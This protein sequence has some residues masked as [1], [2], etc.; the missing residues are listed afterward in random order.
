MV[1]RPNF[2]TTRS[3]CYALAARELINTGETIVLKNYTKGMHNTH[4]FIVIKQKG[5]VHKTFLANK[6]YTCIH[7]VESMKIICVSI[8]FSLYFSMIILIV[9]MIWPLWGKIALQFNYLC[10]TYFFFYYWHYTNSFIVISW[11]FVSF[12]KYE[13]HV[14]QNILTRNV[15]VVIP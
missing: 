3:M 8:F 4:N 2:K 12:F 14:L 6:E 11:S 9:D 1:K 15:S 7:F 5:T 10:V 13:V